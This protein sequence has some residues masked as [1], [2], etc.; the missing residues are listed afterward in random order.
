SESLML[1]GTP[2]RV[3]FEK[4][5]ALLSESYVP[6]NKGKVW[7]GLVRKFDISH[8]SLPAGQRERIPLLIRLIV[9]SIYLAQFLWSRQ[10]PTTCHVDQRY[11]D[12]PGCYR[13]LGLGKIDKAADEEYAM[14]RCEAGDEPCRSQA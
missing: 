1:V 7:A 14:I 4:H 6:A 2:I 12:E 5:G 10:K 9:C 3:A 11:P 8:C 13:L